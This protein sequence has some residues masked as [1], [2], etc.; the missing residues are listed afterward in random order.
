MG[1]SMQT[2]RAGQVR[3]LV[4]LSTCPGVISGLPV[5]FVDTAVERDPRPLP[6]SSETRIKPQGDTAVL[7]CGSTSRGTWPSPRSHVLSMLTAHGPPSPAAQK[8][9]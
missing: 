8:G 6:M 2:C 4:H 9:E 3:A 1:R 7:R 5:P